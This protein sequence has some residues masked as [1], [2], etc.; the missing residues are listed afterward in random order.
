MKLHPL[1]E[2]WFSVLQRS[3]DFKN[4]LFFFLH[5]QLFETN[6][7]TEETLSILMGLKES[8]RVRKAKV[9]NKTMWESVGSGLCKS[10]NLPNSNWPVVWINRIKNR[11]SDRVLLWIFQINTA[12]IN[13]NF[14]SMRVRLNWLTTV[15]K[16]HDTN[17]IRQQSE[18][19]RSRRTFDWRQRKTHLS[20]ELWILESACYWKV[21]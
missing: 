11:V 21:Q 15:N 16:S 13:F 5:H 12:I 3:S 10:G 7:N 20:D 9:K 18:A 6:Q 2:Y 8:D 19:G 4:F 17:S 1:A 14:Y